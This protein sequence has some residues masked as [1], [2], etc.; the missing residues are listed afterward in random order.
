MHNQ[1]QDREQTPNIGSLAQL[2]E[3]IRAAGKP[4]NAR[5]TQLVPQ[6]GL[7]LWDWG[8]IVDHQAV[9][10]PNAVIM[11]FARAFRV[12]WKKLPE[13]HRLDLLAHW[14]SH[15]KPGGTNDKPWPSIEINSSCLLPYQAAACSWGGY[16][17]M[18]CAS[19]IKLATPIELRHT[20]AHEFGHAIS[21]AHGWDA[22]H[23]CALPGAEECVACECQAYSYMACWGFDPFYGRLPKGSFLAE[24]F[25]SATD[26]RE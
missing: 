17:L 15:H 19:S 3:L 10:T 14:Y 21:Y 13:K 26:H 2:R 9:Q 18:F 6:D 5:I 16:R 1:E 24:R 25:D 11:K 23:E 12:T 20:I 4:T 7:H 22:R 8:S